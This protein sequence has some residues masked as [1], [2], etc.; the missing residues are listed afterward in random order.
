M[1]RIKVDFLKAKYKLPVA[2]DRGAFLFTRLLLVVIIVSTM[3]AGALS[4]GVT[5]GED[6]GGLNLFS[7]LSHLV[8]SND[9]PLEGEEEDRMNFLLLGVGGEGHQGSELTD[10]IIFASFRPSNGEVGLLSIPRDLAVPIP[11]HGTTRINA[12]N[13]YNGI[14]GALDVVSDVLDQTIHY[15]IKVNFDGF[16]EMVDEVGGISL[17]VDHSFSDY[18][19]PIRGM[20]EAEC[21]TTET[22]IDEEGNEISVPTYGCRFEILSFQEGWIKMDGETALKFVRSRHGTNGEGSDFARAARQQKVLLALRDKVLS[23]STLF[24]PSRVVRL[25]Q[26][27]QKNIETNI[28]V[29]EMTK[30]ASYI[31]DINEEKIYNH[32]LDDAGPL[33]SAMINGAYLLLPKNNDWGPIE[34]IAANIFS[35]EGSTTLAHTTEQTPKFVRVEVQNGT[36]ISGLAFSASQLLESRGFDVVKIGNASDRGFSDTVIYDLTRGTESESLNQLSELL[37]GRI[38]MSAAGW[39]YTNNIIPTELSITNDNGETQTTES[40]IDFLIILGEKTANLVLR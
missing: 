32:V 28:T 25:F 20:E 8:R 31:P 1:E 5:S 12:A 22:I 33:T 9:K 38:N 40:D 4:Y 6:I 26:D 10:T 16:A 7:T 11:G 29:W 3:T 17:Y 34:R 39:V 23:A 18:S 14:E 35:D 2:Q 30:L 24:N 19:Y 37:E 36:T 21:G 13:V 15:Y 27:L